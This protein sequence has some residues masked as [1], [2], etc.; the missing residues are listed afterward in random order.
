[1][2]AN[3]P[4][5]PLMGQTFAAARFPEPVNHSIVQH[6]RQAKDSGAGQSCSHRQ[7]GKNKE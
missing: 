7:L 1:M 6:G 2:G 5:P 3:G 4:N